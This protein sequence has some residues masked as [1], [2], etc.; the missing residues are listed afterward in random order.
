MWPDV[1]WT[2]VGGRESWKGTHLLP[3]PTPNYLEGS[4]GEEGAPLPGASALLFRSHWMWLEGA[5]HGMT[6]PSSSAP[7]QTIENSKGE[8]GAP[9]PLGPNANN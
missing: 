8:A 5:H 1:C 2:W 4:E 7:P 9:Y 3:F 6:S